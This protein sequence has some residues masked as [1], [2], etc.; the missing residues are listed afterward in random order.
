MKGI[1][2]NATEHA[3]TTVFDEDTWDDLLDA[4][5]CHGSY[6]AIGNYDDSELIGL[7]MAASE[8]T[9]ESP[10]DV[11]R[12]VGRH[13]FS[14]LSE[15]YDN[16][17]NEHT[18]TRDFLRSVNDIIH[19]EVLKMYP[20]S[21]PPT[22]TLHDNDDGS[23]RLIYESHRCL[24]PLAEGLILGAADRFGEVV[25]IETV[26]DDDASRVVYELRFADQ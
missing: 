12:L 13:A 2:F 11:M 20:E 4:A 1:I 10:A 7:V 26:D 14:H 8:T 15:R 16:L 21:K 18:T 25:E 9:G 19:P 5:G 3:V 24:G 22:F 17:I 23:M 6:T